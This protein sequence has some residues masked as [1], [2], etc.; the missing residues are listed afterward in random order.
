MVFNR[1]PLLLIAALSGAACDDPPIGAGSNP[2]VARSTRPS[3]SPP[4]TAASVAASTSAAAPKAPAPPPSSR[5]SATGPLMVKL[6]D[7][8]S[9]PAAKAKRVL[10]VG[11]SMVPLVGF[12]LR[13]AVKANG[14]M[15]WID[16]EESTSTLSW[17]NDRALQKAM[18]KYDPQ[19]IIISLGSNELFDPKPQRRAAAIR[20]LVKDTRG[21]TCL[22]IGPPA[23]KKDTGFIE[24]LKANLGHCRFFDSVAMKLPRM[25]DGRHPSWTGGHRWAVAVWKM[26]GGVRPVPTGSKP[27]KAGAKH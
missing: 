3:A 15:Y 26:L 2:S 8:T 23:W 24:V 17:D 7:G 4:Q 11:D 5:A 20:G 9:V 22:W 21:R 14:G 19:L 1:R 6:D 18:Y 12:Y 13:P 27:T 25:P 10:H 16:S